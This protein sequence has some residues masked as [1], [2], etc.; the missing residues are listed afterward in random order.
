ML[1]QFLSYSPVS[2]DKTFYAVLDNALRNAAVRGVEIKML[3]SDWEKD[4]PAVD[5]LKSLALVPNIDIK[6]HV[7][8]EWSGGYISFARVDHRKYI[9]VDS[10]IFWLGTS[11][12]EKSYFHTSRNVGVVVKNRTLGTK[13]HDI[14]MKSWNGPYAEIIDPAIEYQPRFHGEK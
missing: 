4:H 11:N 7:I 14:F 12:G 13:L 6:F 8:P 5:H 3:I 10:T 1:L 9:C 2:R